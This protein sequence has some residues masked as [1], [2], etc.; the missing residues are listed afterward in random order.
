MKKNKAPSA[1]STDTPLYQARMAAACAKRLRRYAVDILLASH[2]LIAVI[3][4]VSGLKGS[5][6]VALVLFPVSLILNTWVI[7]KEVS[8]G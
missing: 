2:L 4:G 5:A 7:S 8:H 6:V 3:L 1:S